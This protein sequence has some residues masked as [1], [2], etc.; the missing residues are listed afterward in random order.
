MTKYSHEWNKLTIQGILSK[1]CCV[2]FTQITWFYLANKRMTL[3]TWKHLS[4]IRSNFI[5]SG[6]LR[7]NIFFF[8]FL[9]FRIIA[10]AVRVTSLEIKYNLHRRKKLTKNDQTDSRQCVLS[11]SRACWKNF[12][13]RRVYSASSRRKFLEEINNRR[14]KDL[15]LLTVPAGDF[16]TWESGIVW[17]VQWIS[18][19]KLHRDIDTIGF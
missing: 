17:P 16:W 2:C 14:P 15:L 3:V 5:H 18:T 6:N 8:W 13:P 11:A 1:R 4:R 12:S 10:A 19:T 7:T 9:Y